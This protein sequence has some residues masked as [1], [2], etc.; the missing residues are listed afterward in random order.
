MYANTQL[1]FL[2]EDCG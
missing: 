2:D 1:Q